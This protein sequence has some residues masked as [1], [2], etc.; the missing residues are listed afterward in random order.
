MN[1]DKNTAPSMNAQQIA[2]L[3]ARGFTY[4]ATTRSM[5]ALIVADARYPGQDVRADRDGW[6]VVDG[7]HNGCV[8]E[9]ISISHGSAGWCVTHVRRMRGNSKNFGANKMAAAVFGASKLAKH[10]APG[11]GWRLIKRLGA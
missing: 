5:E 1:T 10:M 11:M 9:R 7:S 4:N 2:W 8:A 6:L 3:T